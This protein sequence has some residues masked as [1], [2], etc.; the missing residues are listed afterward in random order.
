MQELEIKNPRLTYL[1]GSLILMPY[2]PEF[3]P[4]ISGRNT[5]IKLKAKGETGLRELFAWQPNKK[6]RV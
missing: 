5:A 4:D 2:F 6:N 3:M 1:I